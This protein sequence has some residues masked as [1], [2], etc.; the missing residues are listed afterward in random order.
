[1]GI[2]NLNSFLRKHCPGIFKTVHLSKYA[3][4]KVAIDTSL[5]L[6]KFKAICA[7]RWLVAFINLVSSLRKNDI[8][9]VFIYD[10]G[11]VPEKEKE[12]AE[13]RAQQ[14]K[15]RDKVL[16]LEELFRE[17]E[18]TGEIDP[19]LEE[20]NK[21][22]SAN[23]QAT[24]QPIKSFLRKA[25]Q[26]IP[27]TQTTPAYNS[28]F[29]ADFVRSKIEK[30]RSYI[31]NIT[32][33]DFEL[34]KQLF[35]ILNIPYYDAPLEAE[36]MCADLCKRKLVDAVLSEDTDV[37]AYEAPIFLTKINTS[38]EIC[39][40]ICFDDVI[41]ELN[42]TGSQFLDLCIMFGCDYNSNIPK[43]G[44]ETSFKY[45]TKYKTIDNLRDQL[46]INVDI[47]NHERVRD[48]FLNHPKYDIDKV[49]YCGQPDVKQLANFLSDNGL[50]YSME[51]IRVNFIHNELVFACS[52]DEETNE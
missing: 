20:I 9:C 42:L 6:C 52:D 23:S 1:M 30:M 10:S 26:L 46:G 24:L 14:E 36:T 48:I 35:E 2:S 37:L 49:P 33:A 21:G 47:L 17:Y 27:I 13:R 5:F 7:D 4:M 45:I 39:V 50:N 31:L 38:E 3:Y 40:E 22:A 18:E 8:H 51:T 44:V 15:Q 12:R 16:L 43:V 28:K 41:R 29:D 19:K 25:T 32:P 34:T 11:A